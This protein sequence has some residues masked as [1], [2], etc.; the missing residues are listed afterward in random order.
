MRTN[1]LPAT[2]PRPSWNLMQPHELSLFTDE[3]TMAQRHEVT[4]QSHISLS[5]L[6]WDS[7]HALLPPLGVRGH[8]S[9]LGS[10]AAVFRSGP[11]ERLCSNSTKRAFHRAGHIGSRRK[12]KAGENVPAVAPPSP[13]LG[14]P[15]KSFTSHLA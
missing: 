7:D 3:D 9:P 13:R 15:Q 14:V 1:N 10:Q 2:Q 12:K 8:I 5:A 11:G 4:C 6:G